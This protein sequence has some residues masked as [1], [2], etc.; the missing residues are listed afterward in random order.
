MTG[1]IL[2]NFCI[3]AQS[4]IDGSSNCHN[5]FFVQGIYS[6][7]DPPNSFRPGRIVSTHYGQGLIGL[8]HSSV[9]TILS[10]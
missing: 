3:R 10:W 9:V 1:E 7:I 6:E 4:T 8:D 5:Q 2:Q